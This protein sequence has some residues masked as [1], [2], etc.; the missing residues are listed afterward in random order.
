MQALA[1]LVGLELGVGAPPAR[2]DD[3][4]GGHAGDARDA[5]QLPVIRSHGP[6]VG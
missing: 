5:E 1:D 2:D 6:R 4:G 3:A